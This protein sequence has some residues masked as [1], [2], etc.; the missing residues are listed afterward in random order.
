MMMHNTDEVGPP[1]CPGYAA[2]KSPGALLLLFH[3]VLA[4]SVD[5]PLSSPFEWL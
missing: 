1:S 3:V 4:L 2:L 5:R